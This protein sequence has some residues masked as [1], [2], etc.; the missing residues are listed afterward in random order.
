[1]SED[2]E[3]V[4]SDAP[5]AE[6]IPET[7]QEVEK[8]SVERVKTE[9]SP[10]RREA[11][12]K[13]RKAKALKKDLKVQ[14]EEKK[15]LPSIY[16]IGTGTLGLGGLALYY[17][18]NQVKNSKPLPEASVPIAQTVPIPAPTQIPYIPY[19]SMTKAEKTTQYWS[20]MLKATH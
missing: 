11:L 10:K 7:V 4:N 16:L 13:A 5:E 17:Y 20:D 14:R 12:T 9:L 2:K 15:Y 1:M 3:I 19:H 18:L 8:V 6:S